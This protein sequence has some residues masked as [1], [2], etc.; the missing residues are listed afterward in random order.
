MQVFM[1]YTI[2]KIGFQVLFPNNP[3]TKSIQKQLNLCCSKIEREKKNTY[4]D[5]SPN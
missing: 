1:Q 3:K 5:E 2:Y 4:P